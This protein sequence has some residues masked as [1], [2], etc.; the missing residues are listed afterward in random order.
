[1]KDSKEGKLV[2][3]ELSRIEGEYYFV[4]KSDGKEVKLHVAQSTQQPGPIKPG[5]QIEAKVDDKNHVL[6]IHGQGSTDR[7][8]LKDPE[9]AP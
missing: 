2:L 6:S 5:D 9:A 8:D 3:G 1:M 7:R 4:K